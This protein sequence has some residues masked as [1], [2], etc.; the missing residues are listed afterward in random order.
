MIVENTDAKPVRGL[1]S[2]LRNISFYVEDVLRVIPDGNFTEDTKNSVISF[3]KIYGLEPTGEVDNATWQK[4]RDVNMELNRIYPAPREFAVF[5]K[6][7]EIN[8]G[9]KVPEL[10][11]L[12]AM[13]YTL[14]LLFQNTPVIEITGIHDDKSVE[15][16][17]F[18]QNLTGLEP[19][20]VIDIP[21]YNMIAD[22]YTSNVAKNLS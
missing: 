15:S 11:V 1:Q 13:I 7:I 17:I 14:F 19:T 16:V 4:I 2:M 3:Q 8:E 9:D 10:F 21:T 20:G 5:E 12:Q 18:I 6:R 22:L